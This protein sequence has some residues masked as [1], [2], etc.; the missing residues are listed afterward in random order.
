MRKRGPFSRSCNPSHR[1]F[2]ALSRTR[3]TEKLSVLFVPVSVSLLEAC[4]YFGER[5]VMTRVIEAR[6]YPRFTRALSTRTKL[7]RGHISWQ[8]VSADAGRS[9]LRH[10]AATK[11]N[12]AS[13]SGHEPTSGSERSGKN[14]CASAFGSPRGAEHKLFGAG[15]GAVLRRDR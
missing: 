7:G 1:Q 8:Q 15:A 6:L 14:A 12:D 10:A 9:R 3:L 13:L 11:W 5:L 4:T 2:P